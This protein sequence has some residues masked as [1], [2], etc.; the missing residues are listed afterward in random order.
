MEVLKLITEGLSNQEIAAQLFIA[1]STVKGYIHSI[2]RKLEVDSRTKTVARAR[3]LHLL[4][5]Q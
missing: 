3:E 4:S 2:F 1:T 5:E